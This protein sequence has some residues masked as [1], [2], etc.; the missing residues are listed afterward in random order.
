MTTFNNNVHCILPA[1]QVVER[2]QETDEGEESYREALL[3]GNLLNFL[4]QELTKL[5]D[6]HAHM[7][8]NCCRVPLNVMLSFCRIV[9]TKKSG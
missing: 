5:V 4:G 3:V 2:G 7:T 8:R 6:I 1:Q 9:Q